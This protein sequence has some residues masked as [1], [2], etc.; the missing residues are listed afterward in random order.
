MKAFSFRYEVVLNTKIRAVEQALHA[1][2]KAQEPVEKLK[3]HIQS[4]QD[5]QEQVAHAMR[6]RELSHT[7]I[8]ELESYQRYFNLIETKKISAQDD[9]LS[10]E[11][12]LA[13]QQ[14]ILKQAMKE[15]KMIEK[16]KEKQYNSWKE[17]VKK[18]EEKLIDETAVLQH[19][20]KGKGSNEE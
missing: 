14:Q 16:L 13:K 7:S 8:D 11:S 18:W 3:A 1:L 2:H 17:S 10:A 6:N 15:K 9:L 4:L 12:N 19:I 20:R 5:E